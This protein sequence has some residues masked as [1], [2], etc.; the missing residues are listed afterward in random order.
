MNNSPTS[1][2]GAQLLFVTYFHNPTLP[3]ENISSISIAFLVN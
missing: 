3:K 1:P 2:V